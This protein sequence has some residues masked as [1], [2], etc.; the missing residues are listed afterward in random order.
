LDIP[1]KKSKKLPFAQPPVI[2]PSKHLLDIP[3][4]ALRINEA[5]ERIDDFIQ[6]K[7]KGH[8]VCL[9]NAYTVSLAWK[10]VELRQILNKADLVLADGMSIVWGG[11]W[12]GVNL[13]H[14]IAGPDLTELICHHAEQ[15][16]Y[17]VYFLGSTSEN[18]REL[19]LVI[20]QRWPRLVISGMYS[21]PMCDKLSPETNQL[22]FEELQKA[23]P[24]ILFIGMSTPK[25]DKWIASHLAHIPA[26]VSI[27]I[28]AAFD[29]LSGRIS[30]A[31]EL[32]QRI[33]LEWLYRL[34]CEP[35][36]L[37]KRYLLGNAIFLSLLTRERLLRKFNPSQKSAQ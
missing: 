16:G 36:R 3:F 9:A 20:N 29:F 10:D 13:P 25:Q 31:P 4:H 15:K 32:F 8:Q 37:W 12:L 17:R 28:G 22:I 5:V 33:G 30:R 27:G 24:D 2:A 18:L 6:D 23:K 19:R 35:R 14:R 7:T 11:R 26:P 34:Y 21:P 1:L